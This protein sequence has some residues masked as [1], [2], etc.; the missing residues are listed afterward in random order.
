MSSITTDFGKG[1]RHLVPG[2]GSPSLADALRDVADD[3]GD[4]AG[5]LSS[6]TTVVVASHTVTMARAGVPVAVEATAGAATGV[7][8]I[9]YSAAPAAGYVRVTFAAGVATLTFNAADAVTAAAVLLSPAPASVRT[10]KG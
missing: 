9:Q 4:L 3:L 6:W 8:Q 1:G 7:M 2:H 5:G 10:L